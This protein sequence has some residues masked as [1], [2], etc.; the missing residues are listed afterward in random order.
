MFI[1]KEGETL[2]GLKEE[3]LIALDIA[4]DVFTVY[5]KDCI[6]TSGRCKGHGDYSHHYKG[7]AV[8]LRS[9]HIDNEYS[10]DLLY[11]LQEELG[12]DYQVLFENV[13]E[14][15]EHYHVEY[16]PIQI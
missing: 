16:D 12:D 6:L 3:M 11:E 5:K 15:T 9:K 8:D 13:G 10:K 7:L 1:V 2:S 4:T 14:D